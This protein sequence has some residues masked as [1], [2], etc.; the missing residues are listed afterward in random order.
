MDI[1]GN[2]EWVKNMVDKDLGGRPTKFTVELGEFICDLI[3]GGKSLNSICAT[4]SDMPYIGTVLRWVLDGE[5]EKT[6]ELKSFAIAYRASMT[7]RNEI[8][9]DQ[10]VDISD[11]KGNDFKKDVNGEIIFDENGNPVIDHDNIQRAKLQ[12]D[13]R[14][15]YA[16]KINPKRYGDKQIVESQ[17]VNNNINIEAEL[18]LTQADYDILTALGWKGK[19]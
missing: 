15:R 2:L 12:V 16:S 14:F 13:T 6:P 19:E 11:Y 8:L 4:V 7:I 17:N 1:Y 5:V 3:V 18:P 10:I 9:F